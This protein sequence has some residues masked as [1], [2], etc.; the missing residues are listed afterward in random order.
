M[1]RNTG[2]HVSLRDNP[3]QNTL[4]ENMLQSLE[5]YNVE[6]NVQLQHPLLLAPPDTVPP[7]DELEMVQT[8]LR[9]LKNRALE[10]ARKA[11]EDLKFI[12]GAM[13]RMREQEKGKAKAAAKV[14]REPSCTFHKLFRKRD[15]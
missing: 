9:A 3:R 7:V 10:R 5:P 6:S 8:E 11:D 14:K 2:L 12:E 13:K 4:C 1:H 15:I